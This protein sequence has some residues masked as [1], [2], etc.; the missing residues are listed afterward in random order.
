MNS[1]HLQSQI[2]ESYAIL[3][4]LQHMLSA[5]EKDRQEKII[6]NKENVGKKLKTISTPQTQEN[7]ANIINKPTARAT[8]VI[9]LFIF[10]LLNPTLG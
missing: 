2:M 7:N 8:A 1:L 5:K 3:D 9:S 4:G 10:V 6:H